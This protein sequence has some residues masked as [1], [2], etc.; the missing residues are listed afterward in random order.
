MDESSM[1][2]EDLTISETT[3]EISRPVMDTV[4]NTPTSSGCIPAASITLDQF[5]RLLDFKL[6]TKLESFQASLTRTIRKEVSDQ[7]AK[8]KSEFTVTTDFLAEEQRDEKPELKTLSDK[9][10]KLEDEKMQLQSE[11][12]QMNKTLQVLDRQVLEETAKLKSSRYPKNDRKIYC[13]G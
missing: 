3:V 5:S 4:K 2:C 6:D 1:S 8:L 12:S 11:L 10:R 7:I 13:M 9:V